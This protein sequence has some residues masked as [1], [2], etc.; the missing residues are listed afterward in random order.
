MRIEHPMRAGRARRIV[1]AVVAFVAF[2]VALGTTVR[3]ARPHVSFPRRALAAPQPAPALHAS[4][5]AHAPPPR[6]LP[7]LKGQTHV[8]SA[9]S[10]DA[11]TLPAAVARFYASRGYDFLFLTDHNYITRIGAVG[12]MLSLPGVELTRNLGHCDPPEPQPHKRCLV[13]VNVLGMDGDARGHVAVWA[14]RSHDRLRAYGEAL[15]RA[16]VLGGVAQL[17]HPNF[18]RPLDAGV[19]DGLVDRGLRLMEI[20]NHAIDFAPAPAPARTP[21]QLWDDVLSSG[22]TLYGVASDDAHDFGTP[23][24]ARRG[25]RRRRPL[26]A[27]HAFVMVRATRD[28]ASIRDALAHGRFYASTGVMLDLAD[29]YDGALR[30]RVA[31]TDRGHFRIVF[32]G[33]RGRVLA[34]FDG[35]SAEY[36]LAQLE[37]HGYVRA[38]V[39]RDDGARAWVQPARG[40]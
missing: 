25:V 15:D 7:F 13:H 10:P 32:V 21:E 12:R 4:V 19:V 33:A 31:E 11:R 18:G 24:P 28:E 36:P 40:P 17:N 22:R 38:V 34:A 9:N 29:A 20:A 8:H 26:T 27:D 16:D 6:L 35:R 23:K 30:V 3:T 1:A 2:T 5:P 14:T 39:T 37:P